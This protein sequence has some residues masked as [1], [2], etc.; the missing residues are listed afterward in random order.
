MSFWFILAWVYFVLAISGQPAFFGCAF[1]FFM[2]GMSKSE[3]E[4]KE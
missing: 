1:L 3:K 4:N 2:L